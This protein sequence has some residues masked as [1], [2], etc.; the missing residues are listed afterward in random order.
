MTDTVSIYGLRDPRTAEIRYIGKTKH[1]G[2]RLCGHL[3]DTRR[4]HTRKANWIAQ[5]LR[6]GLK[7]EVVVIDT[8]AEE[9][10]IAAEIQWIA[11]YRWIGARL[12]NATD[13]GDGMN[14]PSEETRMK[15]TIANT[16]RIPSAEARRRMSE[17]GK[18]RK[19]SADTRRRMSE[20]RKGIVF[21]Q[22]TKDRMSAAWK[23]RAPASPETCERLSAA[24]RTR[25]ERPGER[26]KAIAS[27]A[28]WRETPEGMVHQATSLKEWVATPAGVAH[29]S[30]ASKAH[31]DRPGM[32]ELA[33][34]RT[35]ER[36]ADPESKAHMINALKGRPGGF[37]GHT[38]T[39]EE[40]AKTSASLRATC[41]RCRA[42]KE[43]EGE[44]NAGS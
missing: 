10:W 4:E 43:K 12:T 33:A 26:E 28:D 2:R 14:N 35:R 23:N 1:I 44:Q 19:V 25:M 42:E 17:A 32:R 20:S 39:P 5:L 7:P 15:I 36:M 24:G 3:C 27:L 29:Q 31:W 21:S 6:E 11:Y 41:A 38:H 40:R 16:G 34:Q 13:G 9:N 8:V 18:G 37:T 22:V 30:A